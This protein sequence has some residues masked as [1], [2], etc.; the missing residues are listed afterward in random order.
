M[1]R[2]AG[3]TDVPALA[4]FLQVHA[5]RAMFLRGG[6][7]QFGIGTVDQ[8]FAYRFWLAEGPEGLLAVMGLTNNGYLNVIGPQA[9]P[10][11]WSG[12]AQAL[13]G[14]PCVGLNGP[15]PEVA[16][17]RA[18]LGLLHKRTLLDDEDPHFALDLVDLRIPGG[19]G[20]LR[21]MQA[22][23]K[24]L[25]TGWRWAFDQESLG[26]PATPASQAE[27]EDRAERLIAD[28][29][30]RLLWD[31]HTPLAMTAF[32]AELPDMVQIGSVFT[33]SPLRGR[34]HAR[35]AVALHLQEAR[36]R[37]VTRAILFA[38]SDSAARAYAAIGFSRI[39]RYALVGFETP[40]VIGA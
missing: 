33:P 22:G 2:Q 18:A 7:M 4:A 3:Q 5:D 37:G 39:G 23:D 26:A 17:A 30:G 12:F 9:G 31:G 29:Q 11:I 27:A 13:A 38:A 20:E 15:A 19:V 32:N 25:V 1:I 34:G 8:P 40:Q 10:D 16:A 35:R 24:A 28:G 36:A 21:S 6:L 14:E